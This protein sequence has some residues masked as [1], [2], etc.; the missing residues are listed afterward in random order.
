MTVN[1]SRA[2]LRFDPRS[3]LLL[4]IVTCV[5]VMSCTQEF[6]SLVVTGFVAFLLILCGKPFSALKY[7]IPYVAAV[8]L[9]SFVL[10][11]AHN[12]AAMLLMGILV[13]V[14]ML[15]PVVMSFSL[16]FQTTTISQ[17]MAA[18]QKMHLPNSFIIP[19]AVMFRFIPTLQ[20]EWQGIRQ[21]MAFRDIPLSFGGIIRH[22]LQA[23]EHILIPMLF[24]AS[25]VMDELA[26]ASLA[27]GLDSD[28]ERTSLEEVKFMPS[29]Y[30]LIIS[31]I[32]IMIFWFMYRI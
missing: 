14:R 29:D 21:A 30:L 2:L 3:K 12:G 16:V 5:F 31:C 23:V 18:F 26:A 22:P 17:F 15:L 4:F 27:R 8:M 24:S 11:R 25:S 20:E 9:A 7:Y 1:N 6:P 13:I 28:R 32:T 19:V 10:P